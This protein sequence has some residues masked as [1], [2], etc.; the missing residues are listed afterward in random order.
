MEGPGDPDKAFTSLRHADVYIAFLT[1]T[2][3]MTTLSKI[4][5]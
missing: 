4:L 3:F 2:C 5:G 1:I